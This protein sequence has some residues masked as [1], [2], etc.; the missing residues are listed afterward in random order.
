MMSFFSS[1]SAISSFN[2]NDKDLS[3]K[4]IKIGKWEGKAIEWIVL[5]KEN[6][7]LLLL[8]KTILFQ[9]KYDDTSNNWKDSYICKFLNNEF[10]NEA[11]SPDE[12][13]VIIN[14]K[15]EDVQNAKNDVFL[16]STNEAKILSNYKLRAED[17]W[18]LRTPR[19]DGFSNTIYYTREEGGTGF[20]NVTSKWGIRPAIWIREPEWFRWLYLTDDVR[21]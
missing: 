1:L 5:E 14:V 15:L 12:K 4:V 20:C 16:L 18:L 21:V 2:L 9:E 13:K 6:S 17:N 19:D 8:S 10:Y 3:K 11:F 7:S